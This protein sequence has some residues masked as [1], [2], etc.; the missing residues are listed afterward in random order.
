MPKS[1]KKKPIID[2]ESSIGSDSNTAASDSESQNILDET[3]YIGPFTDKLI[4]DFI[5]EIRKEKNMDRIREN[6]IDPVLCDI[7]DRYFPHM[8][9]LITL[10][11]LIVLLLTLLLWMNFFDRRDHAAST[12]ANQNNIEL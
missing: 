9:T 4:K 2:E 5:H 11:I 7:N 12:A 8:V 10:L 3:N 1:K 6:V